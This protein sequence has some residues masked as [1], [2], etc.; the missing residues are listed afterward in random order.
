MSS[1]PASLVARWRP[2]RHLVWKA[3][4]VWESHCPTSR[5]RWIWQ[6]WHDAFKG[7]CCRITHHY[8]G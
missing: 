3:G 5:S 2:G 8:G 1:P 7:D 4:P 6:T